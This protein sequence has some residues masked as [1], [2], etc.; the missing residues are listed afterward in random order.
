[1]KLYYCFCPANASFKIAMA[2]VS[3]QFSFVFPP[4]ILSSEFLLHLQNLS[5]QKTTY[6]LYKIDTDP[7]Y[8]LKIV[9]SFE[10]ET[11]NVQTVVRF[12]FIMLYY[13][14]DIFPKKNKIY[15]LEIQVS[16][17]LKRLFF[18]LFKFCFQALSVS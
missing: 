12:Q 1:M 8:P 4:Y 2:V 3:I 15:S 6:V 11:I 17:R 14:L 13:D 9:I 5:L 16:D 10:F 7:L 18:T